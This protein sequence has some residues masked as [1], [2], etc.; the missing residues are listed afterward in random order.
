MQ[1]FPRE[2]RID[3]MYFPYYGKKAHVST[4]IEM[5]QIHNNTVQTY[6]PHL[7]RGS[8]NQGSEA[9]CTDNNKTYQEMKNREQMCQNK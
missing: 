7:N 6:Q 2:A 5:Q 9:L 8:L 1:Y 4:S 3:K